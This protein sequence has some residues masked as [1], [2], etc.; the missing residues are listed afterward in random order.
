MGSRALMP[1]REARLRLE[2]ADWYPGISGGVWHNA[3]WVRE[4]VLAQLRHGSPRFLP[5]SRVLADEHFEFQGVADQRERRGERR[6]PALERLPD[7]TFPQ[8]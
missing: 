2:F 4:M 3:A 7:S 6:Q 1:P 5:T 8:D